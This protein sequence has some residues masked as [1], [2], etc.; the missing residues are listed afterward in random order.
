MR[1]GHHL[2]ALKHGLHVAF[3]SRLEANSC[4]KARV[5]IHEA[6]FSLS[7]STFTRILQDRKNPKGCISS[8]HLRTMLDGS[9]VLCVNLYIHI[10]ILVFNLRNSRDTKKRD[11]KDYSR[12]ADLAHS[13]FPK[14]RKA[15]P[16]AS[17]NCG[18]SGI[19]QFSATNQAQTADYRK[20]T[21]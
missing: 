20:V 5:S 8:Q 10:R 6:P 7:P 9:F 19:V 17:I 15:K 18:F 11:E 4:L 1:S 13:S 16:G 21:D 2:T 12:P 3:T 14:P